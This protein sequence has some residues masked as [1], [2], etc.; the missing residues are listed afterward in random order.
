MKGKHKIVV[1]NNRLH[2]EFEIKRNI[3]IIKGDSAT[4]K[5]TL[6]NMI[7][8]FANLGNAS[9]IEIECD[10]PCTVLEGNMWQMLLKN[11]SGNII[12]IDEE[13]QFIRQQEFAEL[14]KV[15]DN[16]FVIITRENLYN[17]PYSVE[18]IYG[19]YS[20]GKYQN[21]KQIYQEMYH[22]Y[23][24]NQDL[25]CKPDKIIV[26]DTNSGYEYFK[27]I[28]KE[29]NIVCESAG[30]KTK[31]FAMLEQL[32]AE[33]ESICV[34]A[35]GAAIGPE[36]DALYKMSVEKGNIKL[37]LPESFE[38][39]IL[40]SELLEDKEIKDIMDKPENYIESQEYFSW[41][42]FFTKLLVDKTAGTYLKYQKGKLNPTYLH[43]KNKNIIVLGIVMAISLSVA[44][45]IGNIFGGIG[46]FFKILNPIILGCMLAVIFNVPMEALSR[47]LER[48]S[49]KVKFLRKEK[50][51]NGISLVVTIVIVVLV[52]AVIMWSII[53]DLIES[54]TGFIKNF[55]NN[56][57]VVTDILDKYDEHLTFINDY[58]EKIDWNSILKK[59]GEVAGAFFQS[60]FTGIPQIGSSLF[61]LSISVIIA[62]YVLMDKRRLL[63]QTERLLEAVFGKKVS[64]KVTGVTNL[65][66]QTYASF[67][68]GQCVEA[69]ILAVLMFITLSIC[70]MPYAGLISIMAAV[71]QFVPYIG[72]FLACVVGA[73]LVLFTNPVLTIW[74]VI[75]FQIVQ[76]I[77]GQFIYPRVVGSSVGLPALFT[78]M[79]VFLGGKFFGLLGMIFFIP[80]TS[81]I[82]QLLRDMVNNRLSS[83]KAG[84]NTTPETGNADTLKADSGS[85]E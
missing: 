32:K 21:T 53:P 70:R 47:Q 75:V 26:E 7:R 44:L 35:D 61:N 77:E 29:K 72:T 25:S 50:A 5:T 56:V 84:N 57:N 24:L 67:L 65:F 31:I 64:S 28:S 52:F 48:L 33:T 73:F 58:V 36:M 69:C 2:Y 18:E 68:T 8:Q 9:G 80:L 23:P 55:D 51:R 81:V 12:F 39:I 19:L 82:Y 66:A 45:N 43:E 34:I 76:F 30:G 6:I 74:F 83:D 71:F 37:Y 1:K 40:S 59:S 27:A 42:R 20:S 17:L 38:W 22:I 11:L 16:Y 3:T 79:A 63:S 15:S 13:N 78:L 46:T 10:A 85:A 41:E 60:I 4:G 14:V 49:K 54:I 62:V